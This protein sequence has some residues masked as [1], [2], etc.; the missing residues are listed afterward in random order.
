MIIFTLFT[1]MIPDMGIGIATSYASEAIPP[2]SFKSIAAGGYKSAAIDENNQ[3]WTWGRN[4]F[5]QLGDGTNTNRSIPVKVK[6]AEGNDF[7]GVKAVSLGRDHT[8]AI[9]ASD[10]VWSWGYNASGQLGNGQNGTG[11]ISVPEQVYGPEGENQLADIK[12]IAAGDNFT[13]ALTNSGNVL[14]WGQNS[15]YQLGNGTS[16]DYSNI[17]VRVLE[18]PEGLPF[19]DVKAIAAGWEYAVALKNDGTVWTWGANYDGQLGYTTETSYEPF[20]RKV[21]SADGGDFKA[22]AISVGI[23][24][25]LAIAEDDTVWAWGSNYSGKLGDGTDADKQYLP[26]RVLNKDGS[27][28]KARQIYG[29]SDFTVAVADNGTVWA[30]GINEYG[31]LGNLTTNEEIPQSNRPLPVKNSDGSQFVLGA[32]D[33]IAAGET[34]SLA[35]KEGKLISWGGNWF[36]QLGNG[37][38][39]IEGGSSKNYAELLKIDLSVVTNFEGDLTTNQTFIR[40]VAPHSTPEESRAVYT[41]EQISTGDESTLRNYFIRKLV[42]SI[43]GQ[44]S[45]EVTDAQLSDGYGD[46]YLL[47]YKDS[48]DP[49]NPLANVLSANDD[50]P[51]SGDYTSAILNQTL[52][53]G[54]E[55]YVVMTSFENHV[56]G[57]VKFKVTG[58]G[59]VTVTDP[60]AANVGKT[61]ITTEDNLDEDGVT[62]IPD[63]DLDTKISNKD[64]EN[65]AQNIEFNINVDGSAPQTSAELLI[66][67]FDVDEELGEADEVFFNGVSIGYLSGADDVWSTSSFNIPIAD[68]H[69][70][71]NTV[72]VT[73]AEGYSLTVDWGQLV[74]DGGS[75]SLG[76]IVSG[77]AAFDQ[78][79]HRLGTEFEILGV[80]SNE[81]FVLQLN[82]IDEYGSNAGVAEY[83]FTT[84]QENE[85]V[86]VDR[87]GFENVR[88]G[89]Y[90]IKAYLLSGDSR[91]MAN[92]KSV[93]VID[94]PASSDATVKTAGTHYLVNDGANTISTDQTQITDSVTVETFLDNLIKVAGADW[95]VVQAGTKMDA[96][97]DFKT[98][99]AKADEDT[100]AGGDKLAVLAEDGTTLK[101]YAITVEGANP[102]DPDVRHMTKEGNVFLGGKYLELGISPAGYFGTTVAAPKL[103]PADPKGFHTAGMY[104]NKL[105]MRVDGDGFGMGEAP[106]TGDFFLP[107]SPTEGF[108]LGFKLT[109][110]GA[111]TVLANYNGGSQGLTNITTED[112]SSG[113]TLKAIIKGTTPDGRLE[114]TQEIWFG[115]NDKVFKTKISARNLGDAALYDV[116][117]TRSVDP[118]QDLDKKGSY[119][120]KNSVTSNPLAD[121]S[122]IVIAKG[123]VTEEPFIFMSPD[124]SAR[125]AIA[126]PTL[127]DPYSAA[128]WQEDGSKLLKAETVDDTGIHLTF[129]IGDLAAGETKTVQMNSSLNPKLDEALEDLG[130]A[131]SSPVH[132]TAAAGNG[133]AT[134]KWDAVPG[135]TGYKI[136]QSTTSGSY[137]AEPVTV[138]GSEYSYEATGLTNGTTYYFVIKATNEGGDSPSSS[139]VSA[140][141]QAAPGAPT[142]IKAVA[143]NGQATVSFTPPAEQGGSTVTGYTVTSVPG[144]VTATGSGS[145]ITVTGLTNGTTY[146]FNVT[147]TNAAGTGVPSAPSNAVVPYAPSAPSNATAPYVPSNQGGSGPASPAPTE[148]GVDVLVN[149]KTENAGKATT[150]TRDNQTVMTIAVDSQK[151]E[152]KLQSEGDH[153]VVTIPVKTNSDVQIGI[154]DG[155]MIKN[156][157]SK[158]AV[159]QLKTDTFAYT[160]PANQINIS[161]I[162]KQVGSNVELKDI[163]VSI[164]VAKP[165]EAQIRAVESSAKQGEFMI[166]TSPV[167][168]NITCTYGSKTVGV[169]KFNAYVERTIAIP[170]G[171]DPNK[172]TTGIV[173]DPDGTSRHVP[174][175]VTVVDGKYYATIN[176]LTNSLYTVVWHPL[177]F[178]DAANHWAKDAINDMGSRMI[179]TGVGDDRFEPNRAITRA[180]FTAIVV[181]A[182]GLKPGVGTNPFTDV[183]TDAWYSDYIKTAIDY[184][185]IAGY[186]A[187]AFGPMDTITREQAMTMIAR[188]MNIT[189]LHVSFADGEIGKL[190]SEFADADKSAQYAAGSIASCVQAGLVTGRE[191]YRIAPKENITRAEVAAIVKRLL[192]KSK[193]I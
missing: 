29:G 19:G 183:K 53:Q 91:M 167:E 191:D 30:W 88:K 66:S 68:V 173:V 187:N 165:K 80:H 55:Y 18:E 121:S 3:L 43:T 144:H 98:A 188:V 34:H 16:V 186:T 110:E 102:G 139:E 127:L 105:G 135:A 9:D 146:T 49:E 119:D 184:K 124:S 190:L 149:G 131:P 134:I 21:L 82:L 115:V 162:S 138:A 125:A 7:T 118:D 48:F 172:I 161:A 12:A 2:S 185:I 153:A 140:I 143:G 175:K 181:R 142:G 97:E 58:P 35:L 137:G 160:L 33:T 45:V 123:A 59:S 40:P 86:R 25:T 87:L 20:P 147:A 169:E 90:T 171:V 156:M 27:P 73:I 113:S 122:A 99:E 148:T 114:L 155:Q 17:P 47:I 84:A 44:Y 116:R 10:R 170:D 61:Y 22:K 83:E 92:S 176:S 111:P 64:P 60:G 38:S 72:K 46:T 101:V 75:D 85:T 71:N 163:K 159:L 141:P 50:T 189:G 28:F 8:V 152:Q 77:K 15:K 79:Q 166:V 93:G 41:G 70:G 164:E 154:L 13:I 109:V 150:T 65:P 120:T 193:L 103:A 132:V 182:L 6:D 157:E 145:P 76:K 52:T 174:T 128:L 31:Q 179:I 133:K 178:K 24:H 158:N 89:H 126:G 151:L 117:Y 136:Y 57:H 104:G 69:Q 78:A 130:K 51:L 106:T 74:I 112:A 56:E 94:I 5:G 23:G 192:Q 26:Q 96:P 180:E 62:P 81:T 54:T 95:K 107:G 32:N 11:A 36:G 1:G 129:K 39:G 42:P 37:T 177:E 100:L 14:S 67:A 63:H 108:G 4:E 168:F